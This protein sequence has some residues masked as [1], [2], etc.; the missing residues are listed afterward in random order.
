MFRHFLSFELRYFLRGW[1]VWIFLLVLGALIFGAVSSDNVTIGGGMGNTHRNAPFVIQTFY[2]VASVLTLLMTT[3]FMNN[4]AIRDYQYNTQQ[5]IFSLPISKNGLLLGRFIG[6]TLIAIIPNLGVSL[7]AILARFAPWADADR[8]GP[9]DWLGHFNGIIAFAIPNTLFIGAILFAVAALFRSTTISFLSALLLLVAFGVTEAITSDMRNETIAAL[10]DPFG[11]RAFDFATKYWTVSERNTRSLGL[12]GLLLWNRVLWVSLSL[13]IFGLVL[14]RISL[15]ERASKSTKPAEVETPAPVSAALPSRKASWAGNASLTQFLGSFGFELKNLVKTPV[16]IVILA[17]ALLNCWIS[18]AFNTSEVFGNRTYPVTYQMAQIIQGSLYLFLIAIVTFFAG[19]LVWREREERMDEIQDSLPMRDWLLY[20]SKLSALLVSIFT[21]LASTIA[22]GVIVQAFR[23]YTRFQLDVYAQDILFRDFSL[24][25]FFSIAAVFFHVVSPNKYIGYFSFIAVLI[26]QTFGLAALDV[27]TRMVSFGSRPSIPYS[28]FYRFAPDSP[29]W[30]W[31]TLYW[32]L[33]SCLLALASIAFYRRG[34][35]TAWNRRTRV[36]GQRMQAGLRTAVL[37]TAVGF[38]ATASWV[39]YN[40]LVL[41]EVLNPKQTRQRQ[42][43]Y[44]KTC[45]KFETINLPRITAVEYQIDLYPET[46]GVEMRGKQ[47]IRNQS[48]KPISEIHFSVERAHSTDIRLDGATLATDDK[49]LSYRIYKLAQP[50]QPNEERTMTFTVKGEQ[51][52]FANSVGRSQFVQNGSFFNNSIAPQIGYQSGG[53]LGDR[54]ERR[55]YGLKEKDRMPDLERNCTTHCRNTYIS[56]S[57]DWVEVDSVI[58][59][60]ADQI[61]IAPGS[62]RKEWTENSRRYFHYKLD[63]ASLNFYSFLSAR[64]EV[65]REKV[66]SPTGDIDIEVYYHKDHAQNVPRMLGAIRKS[67]AYYTANFGPYYHKQV[68]IIEFPRIASFAQAFPGTMPYS[69]SIGFI[70]DLRDPDSIDHVLYIV[71]HEIGHQWWAHQV[72]GANMQGATILSETL[73]QYSALMVLEKEY[74]RDLM[75]RFLEFESDR[76]LRS[77]GVERLKERPLERVEASQ[78][79]IHYQKG[80]LVM[81][82]LKEMIGEDKVN[83][84]LRELAAKFAYANPPYPTS[85][86]LVDRLEAQTPPEY[87]YLI[88]DL[89]KEITLF[90]NRATLATARKLP[91]GRYEVTVE[92]DLKKLKADE[93][94][95]ETEV[96]VNDWIEVGAFA[97]PDKGKKFGRTLHRE[98]LLMNKPHVTKTFTVAELPERAGID[99]FHL[100]VDRI[101][102][103]NTKKVE[104]KQ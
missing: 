56:D 95:N 19:E 35:E 72:V 77:R 32:S 31:F 26:F 61:A 11:Q 79:Y 36:A 74:G 1:M 8:F 103:D 96:T 94:G 84:A 62:L 80:S 42:A 71:A 9:I 34:R 70:A 93:Q 67:I 12:T 57:S 6:A 86:E 55:K 15:S 76:Y 24:F 54:N 28:D 75:R 41:N 100:L 14:R 17:A 101:S 47:T 68:R 88:K 7:G 38:V 99:P 25:V 81:Y 51:R 3:A 29:G 27:S 44:E 48:A 4:S 89:F 87:K 97:K 65:A 13:G 85:Y 59:T 82:Y 78:G 20:V 30:M 53:E 66:A 98:R 5:M 33:F 102:D 18:L 63:K 60:A 21:I 37:V 49:R 23:G 69:E 50:M 16:F 22:V 104:L 73:A 83:A 43:D 90:S 52:G 45:K 46:R 91:D 64:Y 39:F 92:A 2:A 58:S 40:T 10:I